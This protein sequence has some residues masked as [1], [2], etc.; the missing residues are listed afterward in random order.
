MFTTVDIA[1]GGVGCL[2]LLILLLTRA[3][4]KARA[5]IHRR[6]NLRVRDQLTPEELTAWRA[7]LQKT[8]SDEV[9]ALT[10]LDA[11][12]AAKAKKRSGEWHQEHD[13]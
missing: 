5:A 3:E 4:R 12:H 13:E 6:E 10:K 2:L 9:A 7:K 8:H 1:L 11:N